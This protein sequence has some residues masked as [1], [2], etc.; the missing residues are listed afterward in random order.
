MQMSHF[1]SWSMT[2]TPTDYIV[3]KREIA[4]N[5]HFSFPHNVFCPFTNICGSLLASKA[6]NLNNCKMLQTWYRFYNDIKDIYISK[7][8]YN[9]TKYMYLFEKKKSSMKQNLS[10]S[11]TIVTDNTSFCCFFCC[12][13]FFFFL[14]FFK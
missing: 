5:Q 4:N 6:L 3:E 1:F 7:E 10:L 12:F 11:E 8:A 13:L 2:K 14:F 9:Y